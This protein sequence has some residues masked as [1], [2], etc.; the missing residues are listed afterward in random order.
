[1][2]EYYRQ[3]DNCVWRRIGTAGVVVAVNGGE[4]VRLR[5]RAALLWR[6]LAAPMSD[7]DATRSMCE[8]GLIDVGP[9]DARREVV[10]L[11]QMLML[12]GVVEAH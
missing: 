3:R 8:S 5:G 6:L 7:D 4:P 10:R 9:A 11:L 2:S 1:M 12:L